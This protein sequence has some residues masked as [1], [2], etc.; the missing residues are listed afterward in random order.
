MLE[1]RHAETERWQRRMWLAMF[2]DGG[3]R[4]FELDTDQLQELGVVEVGD[5]I[6]AVD[7]D[8]GHPR[9]QFDQRDA[10]IAFV[11]VG[12]FRRVTRDERFGFSDDVGELPVIEVGGLEWHGY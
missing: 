12:P 6:Q 7:D 10:G 2:G 4:G 1:E 9:E 3:L 5:L 11:E 8:F